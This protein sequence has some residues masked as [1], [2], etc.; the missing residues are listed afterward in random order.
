MQGRGGALR[1][2][3]G[4]L[5]VCVIAA[6]VPVNPHTYA[7]RCCCNKVWEWIK[8]TIEALPN[9]C[10]PI[11]ALDANGKTGAYR[12][13][14]GVQRHFDTKHIGRQDAEL[15]NFNGEKLRG[16]AHGQNLAVVNSFFK[17]GPTYYRD[18]ASQASR[19]D[20]WLVPEP[21]MAVVERRR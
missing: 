10:T 18:S 19:I 9:R 20:Y 4:E 15:E 1:I 12:D 8:G 11:I 5:D 3:S 2:K 17:A 13:E 6:Y 14:Y 7:A 16:L 21:L